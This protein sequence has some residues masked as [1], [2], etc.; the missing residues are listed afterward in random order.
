AL[1]RFQLG[2][3][4]GSEELVEQARQGLGAELP[5]EAPELQDFRISIATAQIHRGRPLAA[6]PMLE[7]VL[8]SLAG[9]APE[10]PAR[11]GALS[12]LATAKLMLGDSQ[13]ALAIMRPLVAALE[14]SRP[15]EDLMLQRARS[16]LAHLLAITGQ[17]DEAAALAAKVLEERRLRLPSDHRDLQ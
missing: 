9:V 3:A 6:I 7:Q 12:R 4:I 2:E 13:A 14:A 10:H 16:N 17:V 11:I 15:A 5:D 1:E 8:S